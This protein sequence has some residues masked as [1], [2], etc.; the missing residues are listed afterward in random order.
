MLAN[1]LAVGLMSMGMG[2]S[3][4]KDEP[5]MAQNNWQIVINNNTT[6]EERKNFIVAS[7][8][9]SQSQSNPNIYQSI[10]LWDRDNDHEYNYTTYTI[11]ELNTDDVDIYVPN[12]V[13][14]DY[15]ILIA[16]NSVTITNNQPATPEPVYSYEITFTSRAVYQEMQNMIATN[17]EEAGADIIGS[18]ASGLGIIASIASEFLVGFTNLFYTAGN[19]TPFAI[20]SLVFL[21][22]AVS[23][24]VVKLVLSLIRSN[25]GA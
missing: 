12:D 2:L 19:L 25:T 24:A 6:N 4:I 1:I 11:D 9:V 5:K 18:I 20:F 3:G 16:E 8:N 14:N 15:D 7:Y 13:T 22:I 10:L 21:G 23:F 17:P